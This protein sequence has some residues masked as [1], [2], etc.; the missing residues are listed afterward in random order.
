M[1]YVRTFQMGKHGE[2]SQQ[3]LRE[4]AGFDASQPMEGGNDLLGTSD[5][6]GVARPP[7]D[8]QQDGLAPT[9]CSL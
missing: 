2:L 6:L 3:I 9:L 8:L 5:A 1:S 7:G 4:L